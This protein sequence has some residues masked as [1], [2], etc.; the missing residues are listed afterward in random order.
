MFERDAAERVHRVEDARTNWYLI[1]D[2]GRLTVVD[3][4]LPRSWGSLESAIRRLGRSLADIE[5]VVLTHGHFDHMG[6]ARRAR[7][8]LGV[9]VLAH[10][11]DS[12]VIEHPWRYRHERSRLPYL[13][14]PG[15][16]RIFAGMTAM[17]AIWVKGLGSVQPYAAGE[18]L[19][20]P[21]RPRVIPTPGHTNGHC[22][23]LLAD[24]GAVI[25]GDAFV[26]LDPYTGRRGPCI[27]AGAATAD[28]SRALASLDGL[29]TLPADRA[30]TGH[31]PVWRGNL[32]DAV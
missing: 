8:E 21:G 14:Y 2:D 18:S 27:V 9:P 10:P 15:F 11:A 26:T 23:L 17:G 20:V 22:S 28:T 3:T 1:E 12:E 19:D 29:A 16:A 25:V 13:R 30:L 4:G 6:F 24:R 5:A 7:E 32:A 31:G